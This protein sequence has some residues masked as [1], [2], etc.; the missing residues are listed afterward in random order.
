MST[1]PP[2]RRGPA[3]PSART[4]VMASVK[5]DVATHARVAA[6]ASLAGLDKSAWMSR[7]ISEAVAGLVLIDRRTVYRG[8]PAD[9]EDPPQ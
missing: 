9:Q 5:L 4:H 6:A 8:K 1:Q 3:G 2:R 7:V